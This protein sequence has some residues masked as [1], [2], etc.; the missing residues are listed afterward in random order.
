MP[1]FLAAGH[2]TWDRG[3]A[4][5]ELGGSVSYA[6]R[7]ALKLGWEVAVLTAAG[8]DFEPERD[9]PGVTVFRAASRATTRFENLYDRDGTRSQRVLA[10]A[11][12]VVLDILPDSWRDPDV[13]LLGP[14]IGEL[15]GP[16]APAFSAGI[17]GAAAQGWLREVD[18]QGNVG[19]RSFSEAGATLQGVHAVILSEDDLPGGEEEAATLMRFAPI[20]A[21]TRGWRGARL[22]S[23]E[24][25]FDVPSLPRAEVDPTGA[26][27]VF[28]AAFLL[29]YHETGSL[30][31][32]AAFAG[33]AASCAVE[34]AGT[35]SLGD[36]AEVERRLVLRERMIEDGEWEEG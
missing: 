13:L 32:A 15:R 7:C 36:R 2:V 25:R 27:D 22:L 18:D 11:D 12:D 31:D 6:A 33:C 14:V 29:R 16:W 9:L 8:Q 10:R 1:R 5:D 17:V 19:P 24:G 23:R 20:V 28:A 4:G 3:A 35:S 30:V 26:G 34:G 21:V